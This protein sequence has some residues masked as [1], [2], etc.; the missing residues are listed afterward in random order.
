MAFGKHIVP[1]FAKKPSVL[2]LAPNILAMYGHPIPADIDGR[3]LT[4]CMDTDYV[5]V[6]DIRSGEEN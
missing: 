3:L 5:R 6:L 4:E 2:D 1:A